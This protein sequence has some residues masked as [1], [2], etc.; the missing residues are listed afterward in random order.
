MFCNVLFSRH[1]TPSP[2]MRVV[3]SL[4]FQISYEITNAVIVKMTHTVHD[5][6]LPD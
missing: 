1:P 6:G 2:I 3:F 4:K 5:Q